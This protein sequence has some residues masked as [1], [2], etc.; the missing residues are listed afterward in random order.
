LKRV[1]AMIL[2]DMIGYK[3]LRLGRNDMLSTRWLV[4]TV[5][6]TAHELGHDRYFVD[7]MEYCD[8]DDHVPFL[9]EGVQ[10]LDVIQL[11]TYPYWHKAEDT[12]DKI[13]PQSLKIVADTVL[14]SLPRIEE[15]LLRLRPAP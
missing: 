6:D 4:D 8:D 15:R 3:E 11:D 7:D 1:R 9:K 5:W 14:A 12:L 10:A 2:L 13:S